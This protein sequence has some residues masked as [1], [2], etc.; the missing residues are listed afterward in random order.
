MEH[1]RNMKVPFYY[2]VKCDCGLNAEYV[3]DYQAFPNA[4]LHHLVEYPSNPS[5]KITITRHAD[6]SGKFVGVYDDGSIEA[7]DAS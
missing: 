4:A 2:R 5:H 7:G 6:L 3:D 1:M